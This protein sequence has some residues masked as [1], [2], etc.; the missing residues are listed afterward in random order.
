MPIDNRGVFFPDDLPA[1]YTYNADGTLNYVT[2]TDRDTTQWRQ[3]YTWSAGVLQS[4][5][6]WVKQ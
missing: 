2:V 3:T 1:V 4:V 6:A 5:S